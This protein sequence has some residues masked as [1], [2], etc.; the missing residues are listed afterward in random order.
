[1]G[2][3]LKVSPGIRGRAIWKS[4]SRPSGAEDG[5]QWS[6][7]IWG[8]ESP[9]GEGAQGW[10][11]ARAEGDPSTGLGA[12]Y[13]GLGSG[14]CEESRAARGFPEANEERQ[15]PGLP[16]PPPASGPRIGCQ[17]SPDRK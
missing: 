11:G 15:G 2:H 4:E 13:P 6:C 1:M 16:A 7:E 10:G 3:N 5:S 9:P 8:A 17:G 14:C 12:S